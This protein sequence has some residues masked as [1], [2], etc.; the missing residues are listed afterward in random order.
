MQGVGGS[1]AGD[2]LEE[3]EQ[4]VSVNVVLF[5]DEHWCFKKYVC[6]SMYILNST[7]SIISR[8]ICI[9]VIDIDLLLD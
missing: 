6:L 2:H 5:K 4:E 9:R 8:A 3:V 7:C 1:A